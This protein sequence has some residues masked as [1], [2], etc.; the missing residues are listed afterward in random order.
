[1]PDDF[2]T[3][4]ECGKRLRSIGSHLR[5]AHDLSAIFLAQS[6]GGRQIKELRAGPGCGLMQLN[7]PHKCARSNRL[8]RFRCLGRNAGAFLIPGPHDRLSPPLPVLSEGRGRGAV[9]GYRQATGET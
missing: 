1:M 4:L 5:T 6:S 9:R 7:H 8:G 2:I 3:C